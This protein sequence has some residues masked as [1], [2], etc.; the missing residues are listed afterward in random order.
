MP[1][2]LSFAVLSILKTPNFFAKIP[3]EELVRQF[4]VEF[5]EYRR[6]F[7]DA[8]LAVIDLC[9]TNDANDVRRLATTV[10]LALYQHPSSPTA[11]ATGA[12]LVKW[13]AQRGCYLARLHNLV[14]QLGD[15]DPGKLAAAHLGLIDLITEKPERDV[16]ARAHWHLGRNYLDGR[17]CS[18][19]HRLAK[20]HFKETAR[21]GR[22]LEMLSA[23]LAQAIL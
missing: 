19:D 21:H 12:R 18:H 20:A 8:E 5:S 2:D 10:G 1:F 16:L 14:E 15:R 23:A 7:K 6:G 9:Q 11:R 4:G 22:G 13:Q 17:G 3:S